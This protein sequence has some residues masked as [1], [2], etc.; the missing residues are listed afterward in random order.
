M[1]LKFLKRICWCILHEL[2][3]EKMVFFVV[4]V[5]GGVLAKSIFSSLLCIF[6]STRESF[7]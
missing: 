5:T 4:I 3:P 1:A 6:K 7:N 2:S